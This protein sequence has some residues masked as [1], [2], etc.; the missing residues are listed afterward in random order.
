M[1]GDFGCKLQNWSKGIYLLAVMC[2][3][4][5]N[6]C[7]DVITCNQKVILLKD[8]DN[9]ITIHCLLLHPS[10][11]CAY[12]MQAFLIYLLRVLRVPAKYLLLNTLPSSM[13]FG[14][15]IIH[16]IRIRNVRFFAFSICACYS[17]QFCICIC[18][19]YLLQLLMFRLNTKYSTLDLTIESS[20][21][22]I[23]K[24]RK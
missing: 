12:V 4:F 14:N 19:L 15:W 20:L 2:Y 9:R 23:Y 3:L 11:A 1:L 6:I 24:V 7:T 8:S 5:I 17:M 16:N 18:L 21:F 22:E 10:Y 13:C